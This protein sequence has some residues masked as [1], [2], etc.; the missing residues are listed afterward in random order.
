[1][2]IS[3]PEVPASG[4][5]PGAG[6][7]SGTGQKQQTAASDAFECRLRSGMRWRGALAAG[8]VVLTLFGSTVLT[9]DSW[10]FAP[11]RMFAHAVK[12]NGRV[13]KVE[14][15]GITESGRTLRID[16]SAMGLRRAEVEGQQGR[17]GRLTDEQ[18]ADLARTWNDLHPGDPLVRLEFRKLGRDLVDGEPTAE[19]DELIE[20]WPA[21]PASGDGP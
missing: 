20:A 21:G 16:A 1:M 3:P 8:I 5:D 7:T 2:T 12:P 11:F 6:E 14:F 13:V 18:M 15:R 17:G 10:P 19:F 4:P 9:D